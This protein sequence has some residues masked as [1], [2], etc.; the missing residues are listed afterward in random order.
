[1]PRPPGNKKPTIASRN[2]GRTRDLRLYLSS[3]T[4]N[5][6]IYLRKHE[7]KIVMD[8]TARHTWLRAVGIYLAIYVGSLSSAWS[9]P[10]VR[11]TAVF[12]WQ[13]KFFKHV[14]WLASMLV[15]ASS[16]EGEEILVGGAPLGRIAWQAGARTMAGC[17][18]TTMG[19]TA[20]L[21]GRESPRSGMLFCCSVY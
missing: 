15:S 17:A 5:A 13:R 11:C 9:A 18:S 12:R 19:A 7:E 8:Q 2:A 1:M 21:E 4:A 16:P 10:S 20:R 6:R 3:D 14:L